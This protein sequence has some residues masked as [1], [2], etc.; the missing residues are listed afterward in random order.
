M[1]NA[2][3]TPVLHHVHFTSLPHFCSLFFT[4]SHHLL[5]HFLSLCP[6]PV[7]EEE[8]AMNSTEILEEIQDSP[9]YFKTLLAPGEELPDSTT[10]VNQ[11]L[12][13]C[14]QPLH[15]LSLGAPVDATEGRR[16][17]RFY[18]NENVIDALQKLHQI[19]G[20]T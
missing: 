15:S 16:R 7:Y 14:M 5:I 4:I 2:A 12:K 3:D 8:D 19:D 13:S 6:G 18:L 11:I 17:K 9:D 20:S 10:E 1:K